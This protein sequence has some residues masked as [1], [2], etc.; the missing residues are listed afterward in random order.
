MSVKD[1][2]IEINSIQNANKAVE[3]YHKKRLNKT[4]QGNG[5]YE[6]NGD[7]GIIIHIID[8]DSFNLEYI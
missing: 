4:K 3:R 8:E 6:T 2:L 7:S 1:D 5:V